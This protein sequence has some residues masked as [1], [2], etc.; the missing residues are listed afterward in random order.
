MPGWDTSE[1]DASA[2]RPAAVKDPITA[3]LVSQPNEPIRIPRELAPVAVTEPS[4]G[5]WVFDMGQNMVGW[6]RLTVRGERG[7]QIRLR[8]A[9]V[10]SADGSIYTENLR[11]AAQTET[12]ILSGGGEEVFEPH[13]TYHGFRYVEVMGLAEKPPLDSIVGCA[14]YSAPPETGAFECSEPLLVKLM[15]NIVWTQRDNMPSIPTDCPQ[16]NERLGWMGDAQIFSQAAIFSMDMAGFFTKWIQDI[17]DAQRPGGEFTDFCPDIGA[18]QG[19]APG[20]A[21]AGI[22][23]PWRV[24]ANYGD[25]RVLERHYESA[26]RFIESISKANPDGIWRAARGAE[27]G[28]WLNGDT[29]DIQGYPK[30]GGA[31]PIDVFAT[32]EYAHS[33]ELL[34]KMAVAIGRDADAIDCGKLASEIKAAFN[35]EF[36]GPDGRIEGNTQTGYAMALDFDLLP[37]D[38]RAQAMAHLLEGLDAYGGRLS[39]GFL[40]TPALMAQLVRYGRADI[41][42]RLLLSHDPPS[43]LH[44][45]DCGAT[46]IWERWDCYI[47]GRGQQDPGMNSY[48]HYAFGAVGEWMYRNIGG[49]NPD[50]ASPGWKH[51]IIWPRPGGGITWAKASYA[52]VRGTIATD[53]RIENGAL[54][55]DVTIPANTTA[56]LYVPGK[57]ADAVTESGDPVNKAEGVRYLG[58]EDGCVML[59]LGSGAYSFEVR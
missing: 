19:N 2:W 35:R 36:L 50:P 52:S 31:I 23:V 27:Y 46:T 58:I 59:E 8:H 7:D 44:M 55:L 47:E 51:I 32:A 6:C 16:R 14:L 48:N 56:T 49:I 11:E 4:P 3:A 10:L 1:F 40:G 30:T 42:Y 22:V 41:A 9:E 13:F 43:W 24:Y 34:A 18:N 54:H 17:R 29:T 33:T 53:W 20:W 12:Y 21:D 15:R 37:E 38:R 25:T 5:V 26:K 57:S 39:T 45:I 28:D